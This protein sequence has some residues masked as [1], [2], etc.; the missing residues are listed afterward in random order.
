MLLIINR[1]SI[2]QSI[3]NNLNRMRKLLTIALLTLSVSAFSQGMVKNGTIYKQHPYITTVL[4][5][6]ALFAKGDT[7]GVA[8]FYADSARFID[9]SNP[10]RPSNLK[11][12]K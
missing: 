9:A 1:L 7:V 12:A 4:R 5:L 11:Q 3:T 8:G 10:M 2:I 6:N